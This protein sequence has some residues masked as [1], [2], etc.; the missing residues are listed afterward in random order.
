MGILI[1][2]AT[3]DNEHLA[4]QCVMCQLGYCHI[5]Q[6]GACWECGAIS[7]QQNKTAMAKICIFS[8]REFDFLGED[9]SQVHGFMYGAFLP[10]DRAIEFS[11]QNPSHKVTEGLVGYEPESARDVKV[12][13]RVFAGKVKYREVLDE[14]EDL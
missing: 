7:N 2:C 13:A 9:G 8:K 3:C 4:Y 14:D 10:N 1:F 6:S 11:S 5:S 12:Q